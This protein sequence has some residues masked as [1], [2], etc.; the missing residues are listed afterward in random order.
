[1]KRETLAAALVLAASLFAG[2]DVREARHEDPLAG[3]VEAR[4]LHEQTPAM[5]FWVPALPRHVLHEDLVAVRLEDVHL[6]QATYYGCTNNREEPIGPVHGSSYIAH[7]IVAE[8]GGV[9]LTAPSYTV[10]WWSPELDPDEWYWGPGGTPGITV[11]PELD[12]HYWHH[13]DWRG[14]EGQVPLWYQPRGH[15]E[16]DESPSHVAWWSAELAA[17]MHVGAVVYTLSSGEEIRIETNP[18]E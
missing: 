3:P 2:A 4:L 1:M 17:L 11:W 16:S 14:K 18:T 7:G 5:E 13:A 6:A 8:P 12:V 9:P 10:W 15:I